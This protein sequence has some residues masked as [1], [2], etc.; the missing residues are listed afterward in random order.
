VRNGLAA[1]AGVKPTSIGPL[2]DV[3][4]ALA[5]AVLSTRLQAG[6]MNT[7]GLSNLLIGERE[8][9]YG[10][11]PTGMA[12]ILGLTDFTAGAG[13]DADTQP[14]LGLGWFWPLL[15]LLAAGTGIMFGLKNC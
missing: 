3:V 2:L 6:A 15:L 7:A 8:L 9:V 13:S 14:A 1:F 4:V 5:L 10:T 11:L 12:T